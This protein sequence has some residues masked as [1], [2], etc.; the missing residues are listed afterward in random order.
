MSEKPKK[1]VV[2]KK[3]QRI[4]SDLD[5]LS[6]LS[7]YPVSMLNEFK[8]LYIPETKRWYKMNKGHKVKLLKEALKN[9][10][11]D[12][13]PV[14]ERVYK[15]AQYGVK[16]GK[17]Q[18]YKEEEQKKFMEEGY[19]TSHPLQQKE[20]DEVKHKK[21]FALKTKI[22]LK[23]HQKQ[24][25]INFINSYFNGALLF[26]GVGSGK[27]L[28]S[29]VFSHYY[30]SL[31]PE[32]NV[33]IISP[34]SL[35]FN[36][37]D[38]LR[39]FGLDVK[40]NRYKFET[41]DKF[42][43]NYKNIVNDKTLLIIDESH[44]MRTPITYGTK[45]IEGEEEPID[46]LKTGRKAK[47]IIDASNLVN[48]VLCMT[49]T[50]FVNR[51]Y[52]VEN[53]MT[54]IGQREE[55]LSPDKFN[56][57]IENPD[58]RFD[59][60]KYKIS[61]FSVFDNPELKKEFPKVNEKYVG[62]ELKS[63]YKEIFESIVKKENPYTES[64]NFKQLETLTDDGYKKVNM[65][66]PK[67]YWN[68][69]GFAVLQSIN[70][71]EFT[72][73]KI[74]K[75][76]SEDD[77]LSAFYVAQ[78]Q[79]GNIIDGLKVKFIVDKLK[80]NPNMKSIIYSSFM[81]SSLLPL[82]KVLNDENIKYT[83]ITGTDSI[84]KREKAKADYNNSESGVNVLIISKAG[85]EGV[86]TK[87]TQQFFL[88]EPQWNEATAEQAIARAVRFKSHISLPPKERFVN[89]YRLIVHLPN[90]NKLIKKLE[91]G[92]YEKLLDEKLKDDE[93]KDKILKE[94]IEKVKGSKYAINSAFF[95]KWESDYRIKEKARH[96]SMRAGIGQKKPSYNE[97]KKSGVELYKE[98]YD[99]LIRNVNAFSQ[100]T[101]KWV[102]AS[103][104][105]ND[106]DIW[107]HTAD[108]ILQ[109]NSFRKQYEI[110]KFLNVLKKDIPKIKDF[111]EPFHKELIKALDN[112][113]DPKKI[114][115][116]Q[117]AI[118]E[119][120]SDKVIKLSEDLEEIIG[121]SITEGR[122][123]KQRKK[124]KFKET[125]LQEYFTPTVIADELLS[126][127]DI[128]DEDKP[129]RMLEPT[130][131]YG[132]LVGATLKARGDKEI[133]IDMVEK[134][135]ANRT[136]LTNKIV[137]QPLINLMETPEFEKFEAQNNYDLIVMNP[138]FNPKDSKLYDFDF[139]MR[140][141]D[142]LED[143]GELL[144]IVQTTDTSAKHRKKFKEFI[145]KNVEILKK[146]NKYKWK[147]EDGKQITL[148]FEMIKLTKPKLT[149][150]TPKPKKTIY[151]IHKIK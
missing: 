78:R 114:L 108:V 147:G 123:A 65:P 116:K 4:V 124:E 113:E 57:V 85:T 47:E 89:V 118:L 58:L 102:K 55:P 17:V 97:F 81:S 9:N 21:N 27:T 26:H 129:I 41:Y 131:G 79:F 96:K 46:I 53:T 111:N 93:E 143:G 151:K 99:H 105:A 68:K 24:F 87:N 133:Y 134:N 32:N 28:T 16:Y 94:V 115:E 137:K 44:I 42:I 130:A 37:V 150:K 135:P 20:L 13:P 29:V 2:K 82:M 72:K 101:N 119:K 148:T 128:I 60:F 103:D 5:K 23:P 14:P 18:P 117:Q 8:T 126:Y 63:P 149:K 31:Y 30:L 141:Y 132:A 75:V 136:F 88:F 125:G 84:T 74:D 43:K 52:D 91:N 51:L 11:D 86:D 138:P 40:D 6:C 69:R 64:G 76:L 1:K 3:P 70:K 50:A 104:S 127:S 49:G 121:K 66:D 98:Y 61:Y 122:E 95:N 90:D 56:T 38:T 39:M 33:C 22:V 146:Y 112:D 15:K 106:E 54:I 110:M 34:P 80:E 144:A 100:Y 25:V 142:M 92:T 145:D 83:T 36:F 48:K 71:D 7:K 73:G 59:Y 35:L 109:T 62:I 45:M 67:T 12:L 77:Q 19:S 139:I 140:A 107:G 120:H 10:C